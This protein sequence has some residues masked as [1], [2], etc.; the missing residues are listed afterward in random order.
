M[1]RFHRYLSLLLA[2]ALAVTGSSAACAQSYPSKPIRI[3]VGYAVG[4]VADITA[5]LIAQK[6]SIA[7]GQQVIVDNR[8]S[9]GGIVAG[10]MV[11]KADPDGH[12]LLHINYGN[13]VSAVVFT[14]L[15]YDIE[16][17]FAPVS[18]MGFFDV[19]VLVNKSSPLNSVSDLVAA[20]RATPDRIN[21]G[22]VSIGSGQHMAAELFRATTGANLTLVPFKTTPSLVRAL[23]NNDIQVAFEI[24]APV[25]PLVKNGDLRALAVSSGKRF[26]GLPDV[27]TVQESGVANYD[28]TAWNGIA[29]PAKTPRAIVD[30]L[31]KEINAA[32]ALPDVRQ[33]FQELGIDARGGSPEDLRAILSGEIAKWKVLASDAK[34]EKQ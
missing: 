8:P 18:P 2:A 10:E 29:A 15:P 14:A 12:T 22:T 21:V 20:S 13:A 6:L 3:V 33:K 7:L 9:A 19:L 25:M 28:V 17:D 23:L 34:L 1:F 16:R 5:R 26:S 11:A 31:N 24:G 4:G 30:R 32:L 27:P